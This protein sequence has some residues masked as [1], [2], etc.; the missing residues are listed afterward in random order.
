MATDIES[1]LV[2][3]VQFG[4]S[5]DGRIIQMECHR[6]NGST[7]YLQFEFETMSPVALNLDKALALSAQIQQEAAGGSDPKLLFSS[8]VRTVTEFKATV[9]TDGTPVLV[10]SLGPGLDF[11]LSL[12]HVSIPELIQLL[13]SLEDAR[14]K[15]P[16]KPN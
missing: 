2:S 3:G 8:R 10:I 14:L 11:D 9:A 7:A 15:G 12:A 1:Q 4:F 5:E 16:T 13:Q 6:K